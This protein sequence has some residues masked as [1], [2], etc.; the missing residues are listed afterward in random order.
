MFV[1]TTLFVSGDEFVNM[2]PIEAVS[3]FGGASVTAMRK[4]CIDDAEIGDDFVR[5]ADCA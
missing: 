2:P 5:D 3:I 4:M 1:G